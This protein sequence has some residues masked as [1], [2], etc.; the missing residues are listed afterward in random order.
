[1]PTAHRRNT[2]RPMRPPLRM[3]APVLLAACLA[4]TG[5]AQAA[6]SGIG[7]TSC[8]A[9][10]S[11]GAIAFGNYN[12]NAAGASA[13]TATIS[14]TGTL[15]GIGLLNTIAYTVSLSAGSASTVADRRLVGAGSLG[16]NLY[17]DSGHSTVWGTNTV[18]DSISVLAA[19]IGA[20]VTRNYTVYGR[21]APGQYVAPGAYANTIVVTVTY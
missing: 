1:M 12:P 10:V 11:A 4:W 21:I 15:V 7:L 14:V 19:V 9:T 5:A 18:S 13:A 20:S 3:A 2:A 16:Y 17:T 6:C 8:S